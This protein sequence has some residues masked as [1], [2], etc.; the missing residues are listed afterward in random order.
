MT[1]APSLAPVQR[2]P[3]SPQSI[4]RLLGI[5]PPTHEQSVIIAAPLGPS[6]VIAGAGSGKTETMAARV[7]WLVANGL[8]APEKILGLTFTRKASGEL[9]DR[10]RSR[11]RAFSRAVEPRREPQEEPTV[12]TYAAYAGRLASEHAML[13]GREPG[14]RLLTEAARWQVAD[15]VVRHYDGAFTVE[16]GVVATVT[17]RVLDLAGQLADHLGQPADVLRLSE[18]LRAE[19]VAL[20]RGQRSKLEFPPDVR[21]F[22]ETLTKRAELLPLIAGFAEAKAAAG[23]MDFGD[24]M[25]LAT[26]LAQLPAVAAV[27][28]SRYDVVLLDEYQDTGHAQVAMLSSLFADGRAVTAVGDPL[29]SIYGWRGAS[30]ANIAQFENRFRSAAGE[31]AARFSLLTSWRN[32]RRVLGAAN[33]IAE[34]L[35]ARGDSALVQRPDAGEGRVQ[36][37]YTATV[38]DEAAWVAAALKREW[39]ERADSDWTAGGRT[40]AVLV[41]KRSGIALLAQ[42]LQAAGLP[43]EVVDLGGLLS[44]PEV[45]DI[46]CALHVLTDHNA[47]ASLSRLLTGARWRIGAADL[48]A[49]H[50]RARELAAPAGATELDRA[51]EA[52]RVEPSLVEALDDLGERSRYSPEGFRRLSRCGAMLRGL[53]RRLDLPLPD[54]ISLIESTLGLDIEVSTRAELSDGAADG[55]NADAGRA[56]IDRFIDESARFASDRSGAGV[57]AFLAYLKAAED[58]EYG[59]KPAAVQ[60]Q[61]ERVQVLTVH[62]SKGLEWDV[63]AVA[64]LIEKGFPDQAKSHDWASAPALLPA[65]LRGDRDQLPSLGF[66]GCADRSEA[67]QRLKRHHEE[68]GARHRLEERR[69]AYVAMT[70]AR[71]TLCLSGAAWGGGVTARA[72]SEF[73]RELAER[74][75]SDGFE[76]S[77]WHELADGERNPLQDADH[78]VAWPADPLPPG[79]RERLEKAAEAVRQALADSGSAEQLADAPSAA[80]SARAALW[81]RDVE[82]LLA[83]R[84]A[85]A[86][87][88]DVQV[89]MPAHLSVSDVVALA[90]SEPELARRLRRPLPQ[91]PARQARRGTA[92]HRWLEQRWGGEALMDIEE[93]PGA[94]DEAIEEDELEVFKECFARSEWAERTPLAVEVPFEMSFGRRVVRGRMDAVFQS[95]DGRFTVV[96]WKTGRPPSGADAQA[97]AVQLALY[98][99]AWAQ[100]QGIDDSDLHRVGAAFHYV[101]A[102]RTVAPADL[103]D[104]SQL[105]RL[106]NG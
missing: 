27:E 38:E 7:V 90:S 22:L 68:L 84:R 101:G 31:P 52:E 70:R 8:V 24:Q 92:F 60:V 65:D 42:A 49:L 19:L 61:S 75:T 87:R 95:S 82:L 83:E 13:L 78:S 28:R 12:L 2:L 89:A 45:A 85:A 96:D 69:L 44:L 106:I 104:A 63:V 94:V 55:A 17:D 43:V 33:A 16:P 23:A 20:P 39:D 105:R 5:H 64:G 4:A 80:G 91:R 97:K 67:E 35:R 103:L 51:D 10:I 93:L 50:R 1:A 71:K 11:L 57:P 46:R 47:G 37:A 88:H 79:Q 81:S 14:A 3:Y 76:V 6:V 9:H 72:A 48:V 56:N 62:G 59:L 99:L 66:A 86:E 53:R 21:K 98:R 54:L 100:L 29:Q 36:L 73:L 32:D 25:V 18:R 26:R 102:N 30:A 15:R 40:L 34:P 41:R 58:E 74:A 77:L